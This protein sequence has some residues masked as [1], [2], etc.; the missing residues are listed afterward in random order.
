M[1]TSTGE[2]ESSLTD[3]F[4]DLPIELVLRIIDILALD[5]RDSEPTRARSLVLISRSVR[6]NILPL[7]YEVFA[8]MIKAPLRITGWNGESYSHPA[9]AFLS[10]L[11]CTPSAQPRWHIKVLIFCNPIEFWAAELAPNE[12]EAVTWLIDNL[13]VMHQ[14]DARQLKSAG[15]HAR[16][17]HWLDR[18]VGT[19]LGYSIRRDMTTFAISLW[20]EARE[21][22]SYIRLCTQPVGDLLSPAPTDHEHD[23]FRSWSSAFQYQKLDPL[24]GYVAREVPNDSRGV[25][26]FI[27]VGSDDGFGDLSVAL[28]DDIAQIFE[29]ES[30]AVFN[31]VLVYS[32]EEKDTDISGAAEKLRERCAAQVHGQLWIVRSTVDRKLIARD[33]YLG[34][35]RAFQQGIDPWETGRQIS[36]VILGNRWED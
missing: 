31:V 18:L 14:W 25:F 7:L 17:A 36:E 32:Q 19:G 9:L 28:L 22:R 23:A 1:S 20:Q 27:D 3:S 29:N 11:L 6:R 16:S 10:W 26:I 24:R 33:P 13:I 30:D 34:I 15:I 8:V 21:S 35:A 2:P 12:D 4:Q 5:L